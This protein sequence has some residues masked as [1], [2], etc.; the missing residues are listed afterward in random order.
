LVEA[1]HVFRLPV[2]ASL[3]L[4]DDA[5]ES[6]EGFKVGTCES[7][8]SRRKAYLIEEQEAEVS[9]Q[10]IRSLSSTSIKAFPAH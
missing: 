3:D 5:Q 7:L 10:T 8:A 1:K 9:D 6:F 4:W 2:F